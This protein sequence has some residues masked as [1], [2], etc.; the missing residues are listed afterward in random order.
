MVHRRKREREGQKREM[1]RL[2]LGHTSKKKTDNS[3]FDQ[4]LFWVGQIVTLAQIYLE[5]FER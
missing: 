4:K 1:H 3:L 5:K 2:L